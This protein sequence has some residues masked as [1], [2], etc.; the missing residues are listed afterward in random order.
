MSTFVAGGNVSAN[1]IRQHYLH[2]GGKGHALILVPGITSPAITWGFV[3]ERLGQYFDTYVLDVRGRG[4][5]SS[6]PELDYGTDACAADIPA[7][8]AA[9]GLD[10]Y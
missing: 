3:A 5:S 7:F 2:Y 8:A 1:G 6:G 10:G 4:L 9:L